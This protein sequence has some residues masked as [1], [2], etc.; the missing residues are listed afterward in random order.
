MAFN[1]VWAEKMESRPANIGL[2]DPSADLV[3]I[4]TNAA[5]ADDDTDAN[6]SLLAFLPLVYPGVAYAGMTFQSYQI[7]NTGGGV[8]EATAHY[9]RQSSLYTFEIGGA[10]Q[11]ITQS[12]QT[13]GSYAPAGKTAPN[14]NGAIGV[15]GDK[16]KGVEIHTPTFEWEETFHVLPGI[17]TQAYILGVANLAYQ[18]NLA[19][20]RGFPAFE[21]LFLGCRGSQKGLE[22]TE[23]TFKFSRQ[24]GRA[25]FTVGSGANQ[26]TVV[27]KPGWAYMWIYYNQVLDP[28]SN[29]MVQKPV[30]VYIEQVITS[31]DFSVLGIGT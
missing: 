30:A 3:C 17:I 31:G 20:F 18:A 7:R 19:T 28:V 2:S 27:N 21:V 29:F 11:T 25:N 1:T 13:L 6:Q 10:T 4:G 14:F 16:I 8:W 5:A 12:Q 26:I 24:A 22:D 23:L 15:D 9:T